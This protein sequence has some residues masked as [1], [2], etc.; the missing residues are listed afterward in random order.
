MF[1]DVPSIAAVTQTAGG[2]THCLP[3]V[4][5]PSFGNKVFE[6]SSS[7]AGAVWWNSCLRKLWIKIYIYSY[8]YM[9]VSVCANCSLS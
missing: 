7:R 4:V 2:L 3:F 1:L 8:T 6:D 5:I 9:C